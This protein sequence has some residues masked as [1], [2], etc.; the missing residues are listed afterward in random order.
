MGKHEVGAL[1]VAP[2]VP[3]PMPALTTYVITPHSK[4]YNIYT[5][6]LKYHVNEIY[7]YGHNDIFREET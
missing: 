4:A 1:A 3:P 7:E 6:Q 2:I 5:Q